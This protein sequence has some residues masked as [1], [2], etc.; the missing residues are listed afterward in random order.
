MEENIDEKFY[1]SDKMISYISAYNSKWTGN[2]NKAI[3]N[4]EIAVTVNTRCGQTRADCSDYICNDF[5]ENIDLKQVGQIYGFGKE[6]NPQAGRIYSADGLCPTL[7]TCMGGNRMPKVIS[8]IGEKQSNLKI[9]LCNELIKSGRVQE[10]D[11]IRHSYSNSRMNGKMKDIQQNNIS[12]TL[13]TRCDCLGVV[14][15]FRIRK[16]TPRECFR[17]MGVKDKDFERIAQ[18]QSNASLYHLAGD[19]IV[20]TVLCAIFLQMCDKTKKEPFDYYLQEFYK[21]IGEQ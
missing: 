20:T 17:L 19:S 11:V 4:R 13:D 9:Q 2:N 1:L 7:D 6:K 8:D 18:N 16:L 21:K 5:P 10:Y 14:K 12:P 15:D 3:I